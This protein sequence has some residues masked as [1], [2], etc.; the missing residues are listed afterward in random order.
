MI[1]KCVAYCIIYLLLFSFTATAQP[2]LPDITATVSRGAI[3]VYWNCQFNAVKSITVL[4]APD[5]VY[6]YQTIGSFKNPE[7]GYQE[8]IDTHPAEGYNCYK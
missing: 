5:S 2:A 7:K 1:P 8:F 3:I 4:R 6:N